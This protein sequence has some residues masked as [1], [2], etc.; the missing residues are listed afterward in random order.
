MFIYSLKLK[1]PLI[2]RAN[3]FDRAYL[4][5]H[6][7]QEIYKE[8]FRYAIVF[9]LGRTSALQLQE[10]L[11]KAVTL[12]HPVSRFAKDV[13]LPEDFRESFHLK[14]WVLGLPLL[15]KSA[16][17]EMPRYLVSSRMYNMGRR[18]SFGRSSGRSSQ[19]QIPPDLFSDLAYLQTPKKNL[20]PVCIACPRFIAHQA[21]E[22]TLGSKVCLDTLVLGPRYPA[23]PTP[24]TVTPEMVGD[25][26]NL[27]PALEKNGVQDN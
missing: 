13:T 8:L 15:P 11:K 26:E 23:R 16:K 2:T 6:G 4:V 27:Q 3:P 21:G 7:N 25:N 18:R 1:R 9:P 17:E 12:V 10:Y 24:T 14:D 19:H 20:R 5:E 22:C